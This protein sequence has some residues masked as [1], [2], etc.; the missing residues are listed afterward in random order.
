MK[1]H[2]KIISLVL[3]FS[4]ILAMCSCTSKPSSGSGVVH[5]DAQSKPEKP[6]GEITDP[7]PT[8]TDPSDPTPVPTTPPNTNDVVDMTLSDLMYIS[9]LC[10]GTTP[11]ASTELLT[12]VLGIDKYQ[13]EDSN[14]GSSG[15]PMERFLRDLSKDVSVNGVVFRSIGIYSNDS[16]LVSGVEYTVRE[17]AIFDSNEAFD[18]ELYYDT[19]Y[20]VFYNNFGGPDNNYHA[21]WVDFDKSGN[22]GWKYHDNCW[23]SMFWGVSCQ[24][25]KGND[26]FV[27]GIECDDPANH[28]YGSGTTPVPTVDPEDL[29]DNS[30]EDV[31]DMMHSVVGL[32]IKTA[33]SK[34]R[35]FFGVDIGKSSVNEGESGISTAYTYNVNVMIEGVV[36]N[37]IELDVNMDGTV[38]YVGFFNTVASDELLQDYCA[39]FKEILD[40]FMGDPDVE[41]PLDDDNTMIEFY[42]YY[43]GDQVYVAV[44]A[45]YSG[46]G[47]SSLWLTYSDDS[48]R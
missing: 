6:Y 36:F 9:D 19:L 35:D 17:T 44:G 20:T 3:A 4:M 31:Y 45:Y 12:A 18:S 48:L 30:Y 33:E 15:L 2:I 32:N 10:I 41:Y 38:F 16:G 26:Q 14:Y 22:Y 37:S 34:V 8:I 29:T 46:L 43:D 25:V 21:S 11:D 40:D 42:D 5:N 1:K 7:L 13:I 28:G 27:I 24:S 39:Y 23:V 47:F